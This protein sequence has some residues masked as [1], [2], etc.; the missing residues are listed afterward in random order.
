MR[1]AYAAWPSLRPPRCLLQRDGLPE[2]R[3]TEILEVEAIVDIHHWAAKSDP[4]VLVS[5]P[6]DVP[7]DGRSI[8]KRQY[9]PLVD[10]RDGAVENSDLCT[11]FRQID[12]IANHI[13]AAKAHRR[14][15]AC[16]IAKIIAP[17]ENAHVI[18]RSDI[19][20]ESISAK[21]ARSRLFHHTQF[22]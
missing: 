13:R 16:R 1:N 19:T 8:E 12:Q 10:V 15:L 18:G 5:Y 6:R 21:F 20:V 2:K 22:L 3:A 17:L 9:N 14:M 4:D 7:I 11:G